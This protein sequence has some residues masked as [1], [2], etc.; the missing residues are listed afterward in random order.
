MTA[1]SAET[2]ENALAWRVGMLRYDETALS[3]IA[4][5]FNRYNSRQMIVTDPEAASIR[6]GGMFPSSNPAAFARLLRDAYGLKVEETAD[7][8][9]IS[10]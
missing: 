6:I 9:K 4:A 3:E 1:R 7:T 8:I 10:N 2:V 5:D